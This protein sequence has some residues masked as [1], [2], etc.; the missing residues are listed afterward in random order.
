M[1]NASPRIILARNYVRAI[2]WKHFV[3]QVSSVEIALK[4]FPNLKQ[5]CLWNNLFPFHQGHRFDIIQNYP[6]LRRVITCLEYQSNIPQNAFGTPFW[7]SITHLQ[8]NYYAPITSSSS[9]FQ[10][11]LFATMPSLTHLALSGMRGNCSEPDVDLAFSYV[12]ESFPPSLTLCLLSLVAPTGVDRSHRLT[13]M[14]TASGKTDERI[15]VW[16]FIPDDNSD[17]IVVTNGGFTYAAWCKARGEIE[18]YWEAG[19]TILKRRQERVRA[20]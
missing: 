17:E 16:S 7:M 10:R 3:P 2:A 8:V 18:S 20:A 6:S 12:R 19:E 14:V 4:Y 9:P 15:V 5:I 1:S 13:E 11:P